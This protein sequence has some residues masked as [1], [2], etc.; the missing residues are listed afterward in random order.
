MFGESPIENSTMFLCIVARAVMKKT[1]F[2]KADKVLK[3][4]ISCETQRT[5]NCKQTKNPVLLVWNK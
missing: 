2:G 3:I 4:D 1:S 5:I